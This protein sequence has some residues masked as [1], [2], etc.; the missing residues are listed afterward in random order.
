MKDSPQIEGRTVRILVVDDEEIVLS[1][2]R[3]ALEDAG[4]EIELAPSSAVALQKAESEYFDFLLTDI[5]MPECDGIELAQR[6]REKINGIGVIFMTGYAN[7]SSAKDAI[8]EGAYDY[9][10]KPFELNEMRQ[11]VRNAVKKKQK[12]TEK[13]LVT[14][15]GRLSDL[16]Q[17]I[18]TVG[19]MQSLMRLSLGFVMMQGKVSRGAIVYRSS[20]ENEI[21]V[22]G[23]AN[24][25]ESQFEESS[26]KIARD[27][28]ACS[29][30]TLNAPFTISS[31]E[32][33]PVYRNSGNPEA[34]AVLIPS[35]HTP[36][37][38]LVNIALRRGPKLYG[39]LILGLPPDAETMKGSELQLLSITANQIAISLENIILLDETRNAYARLKELQEQTIQ[40]EKMAVRGQMSAEIGHELNNFLGVASGNLS[41]LEHHLRKQNYQELDKYLGA[42]MNNME[43]IRKFSQGLMDFSALTPNFELCSITSLVT[44]VI[45]YLK[46]QNH[47]RNIDFRLAVPHVPLFSLADMSQ[48]QQLLYNLVNNA[49]DAIHEKG[50]GFAGLIEVEIKYSGG[51]E[52]FILRVTDNGTGID[53]ERQEIAFQQRFTTKK[54]GHGF[55]LLVCRRII[56]IHGGTLKVDSTPD[57]GT[58]IAVNFPIR[59]SVESP[60]GISS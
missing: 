32:E 37:D 20:H 36:G 42:V 44:D 18:Y 21:R 45:E 58:V 1:L 51:D 8:K 31:L 10:M 39:F 48:L 19:D 25:N 22:I 12:D 47:M 28:L 46:A 5:R 57:V 38:R 60:A 17:L 26:H 29:D 27:Y 35:W 49:A 34:G 33:H 9:I 23:T 40:L 54:D 11:A 6:I 56:D 15:L 30:P 14:E 59:V 7:L 2:V 13:T 53:K 4:Y 43:S 41:L 16:N 55:G 50:D 24:L 3:D 52:N